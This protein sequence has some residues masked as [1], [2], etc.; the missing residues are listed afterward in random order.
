MDC[1][2][3]EA[4][5]RALAAAAPIFNRLGEMNRTLAD[6]LP[7][8]ISIGIG[9]HAGSVI[10]GGLGYRERFLLTA[11]GDA[12]HV[13]ARLQEL[14]KEYGCRVVVSD[15]VGE[16]A[17]VDLSSMPAQEI[18]VRGRA[19]PLTIRAIGDAERIAAPVRPAGER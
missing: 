7:Q 18:R 3:K 17:G 2:P 8:P 13:A 14:T 9:I 6:D 4:C 12:V 11:I 10:L 1:G 15:I 5:R 19:A 16:T